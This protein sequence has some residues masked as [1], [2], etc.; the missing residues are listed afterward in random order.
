MGVF[1]WGPAP[2]DGSGTDGL[3]GGN[4][5]TNAYAPAPGTGGGPNPTDGTPDPASGGPIEVTGAAG[6]VVKLGIGNP[7]VLVKIGK[8]S[9][10]FAVNND[11]FFNETTSSPPGWSGDTPVQC[12]ID[13][14]ANAVPS[15]NPNYIS[16]SQGISIPITTTTTTMTTPTTTTTTTPTTTTTTTTT[17]TPTTTTTSKTTTT[18]TPTTTTTSKTT[19][20]TTPTT[21]TT[22]KTT[23]TTTPTTTT[24]SKT[25]TTT[26]PTTTTTSK[27]TTTT[28]TPTTTTTTKTTTTTTTTSAGAPSVFDVF[29]HF[30][31]S[32]SPVLI[33]GQGLSNATEVDFGTQPAIFLQLGGNVIIA[34]APPEPTGTKV[35]V[36]VTTLLGTSATSR[37]DRFTFAPGSGNVFGFPILG[38]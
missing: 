20:T 12:G 25:T 36:T 13:T 28:T 37:A 9:Y 4:P 5:T 21:T 6:Q 8:P 23:T 15:P 14:S 27:T 1:S 29:P 34:L 30:A 26:T 31:R 11:I 22:S 2:V 33:V 32:W 18:T 35:D 17:T 3:P 38:F 10:E 24:T 16:V 7:N 19:T